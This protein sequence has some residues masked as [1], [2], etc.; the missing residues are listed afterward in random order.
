MSSISCYILLFLPVITHA[1]TCLKYWNKLVICRYF[2]ADNINFLQCLLLRKPEM[3]P[4]LIAILQSNCF[5]FSLF[6][7]IY[8]IHNEC[9][10]PTWISRESKAQDQSACFEK[11]NCFFFSF[12]ACCRECVEPMELEGRHKIWF[13]VCKGI[14]NDDK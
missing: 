7:L 4:F 8:C 1:K 2:S 6:L 10:G 9:E 14:K 11:G 12:T 13:K 5:F 3:T